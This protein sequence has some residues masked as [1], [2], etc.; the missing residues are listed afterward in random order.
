MLVD[1]FFLTVWY[2]IVNIGRIW[3][4]ASTVYPFTENAMLKTSVGNS[5]G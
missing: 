2:V 3:L 4:V 1:F 5:M